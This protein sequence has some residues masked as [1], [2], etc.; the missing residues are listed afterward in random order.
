M[1]FVTQEREGFGSSAD[2]TEDP[3]GCRLAIHSDAR[4]PRQVAS[5]LPAWTPREHSFIHMARMPAAWAPV[6]SRLGGHRPHDALRRSDVEGAT[7]V[8]IAGSGFT[9]SRSPAMRT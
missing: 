7:R 8:D 6:M 9:M 3:R 1:R 2:A 5:P 4:S